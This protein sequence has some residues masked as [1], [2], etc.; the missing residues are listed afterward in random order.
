MSPPSTAPRP[1][2]IGISPASCPMRYASG[3]AESRRDRQA[4]RWRPTGSRCRTGGSRRRRQWR[5]VSLTKSLTA[6]RAPVPR[7]MASSSSHHTQPC[8]RWRRCLA[9]SPASRGTSVSSPAIARVAASAG[10]REIRGDTGLAGTPAAPSQPST[11]TAPAART[12]PSSLDV[13]G[14]FLNLAQHRPPRAA[15]SCLVECVACSRSG[16]ASD[17]E[18]GASRSA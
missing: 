6:P 5:P 3:V 7:A 8:G 9:S 15:C 2:G 1:P 12:R 14:G 10:R 4:G 16:A 17:I 11:A 13:G 18:P